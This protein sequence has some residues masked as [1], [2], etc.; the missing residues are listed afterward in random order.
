MSDIKWM[1]IDVLSAALTKKMLAKQR[2]ANV[3]R[4]HGG[5]MQANAMSN[6][7]V[8]TGHLKNSITLAV[9]DTKAEVEST[10]AYAVYQEY[11]TRYQPGTPHI[12]P[13][14][15]AEIGPFLDDIKKVIR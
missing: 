1:G 11:G 9:N 14:F 2:A 3:I 5:K 15:R 4:S 13:A 12:R 7:P 8:D 10:A 6:A